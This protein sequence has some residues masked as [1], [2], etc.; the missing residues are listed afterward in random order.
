MII[1]ENPSVELLLLFMSLD[2]HDIADKANWKKMLPKDSLNN[3]GLLVSSRNLVIE[4]SKAM[5]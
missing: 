4:K 1:S 3:F 2:F 5:L